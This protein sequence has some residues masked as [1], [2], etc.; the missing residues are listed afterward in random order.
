VIQSQESIGRVRGELAD[1]FSNSRAK[2]LRF[3]ETRLLGSM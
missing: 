2:K 1:F 3:V